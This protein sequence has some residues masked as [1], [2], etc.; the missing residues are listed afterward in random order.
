MIFVIISYYWL[1]ENDKAQDLRDQ[2]FQLTKSDAN[3]YFIVRYH[4]HKDH[5]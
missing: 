4:Q 3:F 2:Q 1:F 5:C